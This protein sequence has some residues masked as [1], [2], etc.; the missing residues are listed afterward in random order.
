MLEDRVHVNPEA[1]DGVYVSLTVH[2]SSLKTRLYTFLSSQNILRLGREPAHLG[3][4]D[5]Q[6][7]VDPF[8]HTRQR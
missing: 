1:V 4:L 6:A 8:H 7:Q 5:D 3:D 2:R